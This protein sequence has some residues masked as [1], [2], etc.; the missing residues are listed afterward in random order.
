ME[1]R[2]LLAPK[3]LVDVAYR[4][5]R[6]QII[7]GSLAAGEKLRV[8]H[9]R[10]RLGV[11]A[12]PLREA[13]SRLTAEKLVHA[14]GQRGFRVAPMSLSELDDLT[15]NRVLLEARAVELSVEKGDITWESTLVAAHHALSRADR[16]L[17]GKDVD[18]ADWEERNAVFHDA[19]VSA[20]GSPWLLDLREVL[21]DQHSR[22]RAMSVNL[23][24]RRGGGRDVGAEHDEIVKAALARQSKRASSLVAEHI[25]ATAVLLRSTL[26]DHL[27]A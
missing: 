18:V 11:G 10:E 25:R 19:L 21:F 15:D 6:K 2:R 7:D 1:A 9:L 16:R 4:A 5:M 8:E 24:R 17:R 22:Y 23:V 14:E 26:D 27:P 13:L 12:T 20:C 3:T